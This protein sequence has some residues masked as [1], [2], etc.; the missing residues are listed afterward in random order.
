[1]GSRSALSERED[2]SV[3][4]GALRRGGRRRR[5]AQEHEHAVGTRGPPGDCAFRPVGEPGGLARG[6]R[7][8]RD[9]RSPEASGEGRLPAL[10]SAPR[11]ELAVSRGAGRG[12]S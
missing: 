2:G 6:G 12:L 8:W 9:R 1:M 4:P 10:D 3:A 7:G 5:R 11:R